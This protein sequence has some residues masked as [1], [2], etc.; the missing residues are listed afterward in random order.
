MLKGTVKWFNIK[1]GYGFI[2]GDDNVDYF[3]Y[4]KD[5]VCDGFKKLKPEQRVSFDTYEGKNGIQA[6]NVTPIK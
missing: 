4:Y 1:H 5:I 2:A 6:G 3:V